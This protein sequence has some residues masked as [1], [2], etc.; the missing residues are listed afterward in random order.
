MALPAVDE[1]VVAVQAVLRAFS[2]LVDS[3]S[4]SDLLTSEV[5]LWEAAGA[6]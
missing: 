4:C 6:R 1:R 5:A 2:R 3:G